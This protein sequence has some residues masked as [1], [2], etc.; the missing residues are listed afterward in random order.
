MASRAS[1]KPFDVERRAG[2]VITVLEAATIGIFDAIV[3]LQDR[4][5]VGEARLAGIAAIRGDPIDDA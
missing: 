2:D 4:L 1:G 5:D 3:D